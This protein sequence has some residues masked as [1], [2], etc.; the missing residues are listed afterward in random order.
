M[1]NDPQSHLFPSVPQCFRRVHPRESQPHPS[2]LSVTITPT[3]L[4]SDPLPT[5]LLF[6][7]PEPNSLRCS[8]DPVP[9]LQHRPPPGFLHQEPPQGHTVPP[10]FMGRNS[11]AITKQPC[12]A[13][14]L[15]A[16]ANEPLEAFLNGEY[17]TPCPL[18]PEQCP[19]CRIRH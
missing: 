11:T 14:T 15:P 3:S 4:H 13:P 7:H 6:F 8:P 2:F 9:V 10:T 18:S 12:P 5:S 16:T 17:G 1:L 19:L